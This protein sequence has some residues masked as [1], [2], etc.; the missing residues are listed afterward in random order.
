MARIEASAE[1]IELE[2]DY[3]PVAGLLVT[4]GKCGHEVE[5]FGTSDR[6]E[7]MGGVMLAQE[8]PLGER[9]FYVVDVA[10]G[11]ENEV[12]V[13]Q[14]TPRYKPPL[15]AMAELAKLKQKPRR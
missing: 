15:D 11:Y 10:S 3:A 8:C 4:C 5:V 12:E 6:S 14:R 13:F 9:N 7:R 1:E 2:G